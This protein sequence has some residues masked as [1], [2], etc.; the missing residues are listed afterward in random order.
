[1]PMGSNDRKIPWVI[2]NPRTLSIGPLDLCILGFTVLPNY[3]ARFPVAR[4]LQGYWPTEGVRAWDP[5]TLG[6]EVCRRGQ[7]V[8]GHRCR[9]LWHFPANISR[10]SI[11]PWPTRSRSIGVN[12]TRSN[13][14]AKALAAWHHFPPNSQG[15]GRKPSV[16]RPWDRRWPAHHPCP[17]GAGVE[18][19]QITIRIAPCSPPFHSMQV[20]ETQGCV[21]LL[22]SIHWKSHYQPQLSNGGYSADVAEV[23]DGGRAAVSFRPVMLT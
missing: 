21:S 12:G 13:C 7:L 8:L 3:F 10:C 4:E 16:P 20:N 17:P 2:V 1:M 22:G 15:T 6:R 19:W 14:A 9:S 11:N 18:I 23:E 5:L